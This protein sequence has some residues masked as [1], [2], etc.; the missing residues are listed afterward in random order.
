M[1]SQAIQNTQSIVHSVAAF[2]G[3]SG[4]IA[5]CVTHANSFEQTEIPELSDWQAA[6]AAFAAKAESGTAE[7]CE[8]LKSG[9]DP[10]DFLPQL[11]SISAEL[12]NLCTQITTVDTHMAAFRTMFNTDVASLSQYAAQLSGDVQKYQS[13]QHHYET[14][15]A[16]IKK[17]IDVING[18]SFGLPIVKLASELASLIQKGKTTEAMLSDSRQKVAQFKAQMVNAAH[19]QSLAHQLGDMIGKLGVA[20]QDARNAAT[21]AEAKLKNDKDFIADA[22]REDAVLYLNALKASLGQLRQITA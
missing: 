12:D 13:L 14:E 19:A 9:A 6:A 10:K 21:I 15:A 7:I 11:R 16:H 1:L 3:G 17:R 18:I 8:K 5:I 22:E 2:Q 4:P 20:V